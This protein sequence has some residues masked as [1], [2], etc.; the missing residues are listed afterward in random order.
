M[1][2]TAGRESK[3]VRGVSATPLVQGQRSA[4]PLLPRGQSTASHISRWPRQAGTQEAKL[5]LQ[6]DA[7]GADPPC[8]Q[9]NLKVPLIVIFRHKSLMIN[10]LKS[11]KM[12]QYQNHLSRQRKA[13][14]TEQKEMTQKRLQQSQLVR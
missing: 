11:H 1:I 6:T 9:R 5:C 14:T 10:I 2:V 7:P 3:T 13:S 12:I 8:M 4:E